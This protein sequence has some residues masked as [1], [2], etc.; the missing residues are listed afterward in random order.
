MDEVFFTDPSTVPYTT[1]GGV[2]NDRAVCGTEIFSVEDKGLS[3]DGGGAKDRPLQYA[4]QV[5]DESRELRHF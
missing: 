3:I 4:F 1:L 5:H 2:V